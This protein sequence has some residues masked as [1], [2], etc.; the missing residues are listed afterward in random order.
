M[1][2]MLNPGHRLRTVAIAAL[3]ICAAQG[4]ASTALG[5]EVKYDPL[6]NSLDFIGDAASEVVTVSSPAAGVVR[7]T[8]VSGSLT[9]AAAGCTSTDPLTVDCTITPDLVFLDLGG[10]DDTATVADSVP[11]GIAATFDGGAG[12]DTMTGGAGDDLFA[13]GSSLG[14]DGFGDVVVG[15][16]GSDVVTYQLRTTAVAISLDGVAND[17]EGGENDNVDPSAE[18]IIGGGGPDHL[19]G[20]GEADHLEGGP[21]GDQLAGYGG[22]DVLEGGDGHDQFLM[23]D[24]ATADGSGDRIV[25]GEGVDIAF[26]RRSVGVD[27][28]LDGVANDGEPGEND[29]LGA[30]VENLVGGSGG[31]TLR[32]SDAANV[33]D[34]GRGGDTLIGE[35]GDDFFPMGTDPSPESGISH[36]VG[37]VVKGGPGVDGISYEERTRILMVTLDDVAN[38]GQGPEGDNIGIDV[39]KVSG[40]SG[41]DLITGSAADNELH[42]GAGNDRIV[43]GPGSDSLFGDEGDDNISSDDGVPDRIDC[44]ADADIARS[45]PLETSVV[46]CERQTIIRPRISTGPPATPTQTTP[47][48][49]ALPEG[50][51]KSQIGRPS[52]NRNGTLLVPVSCPAITTF[53]CGISVDAFRPRGKSRRILL[54]ALRSIPPGAQRTL[55]LPLVEGGLARAVKDG[56]VIVEVRLDF[57]Y[58]GDF[59]NSR[60]FLRTVVSPPRP[61]PLARGARRSKA[62][63]SPSRVT[64]RKART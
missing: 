45:D 24:R 14:D 10:G 44:G 34:G 38:D 61:R 28:S 32:G 7:F 31:D 42:G 11:A 27:L 17:G 12:S 1:R 8:V 48:A 16:G 25:G 47:P 22:P 15:Q 19:V 5:A 60:G 51:G 53:P 64:P 52:F 63:S 29:N 3:T 33:L 39:E 54:H 36:D 46:G 23:N 58:P 21:G 20:T 18:A 59:R 6:V 50:F 30:D 4:T 49:P 41:S 55:G 57:H 13:M 56:R 62:A 37:D 9:T 40:G 2:R 26:Y 43:G 35:G